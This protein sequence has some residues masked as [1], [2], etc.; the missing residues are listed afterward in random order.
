MV[1]L[2]ATDVGVPLQVPGLS[3]HRE[4][5]RLVEAGLTPLGGPADRHDQPCARPGM[6]DS[7]GTIE[8]GKLAD[9]VLLDATPSRT[10]GTRRRSAPLL[11]TAGCTAGPISTGFWLGR[12][13]EEGL[14]TR[15]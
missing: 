1:L 10:S 15:S 9:L 13:V 11:P 2:A 12:K 5:V 14:R 7:L 4:L 3:L 6:A 8:P